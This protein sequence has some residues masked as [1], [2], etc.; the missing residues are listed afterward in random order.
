MVTSRCRAEHGRVDHGGEDE[1]ERDAGRHLPALHQS[2]AAAADVRDAVQMP[3]FQMRP[4]RVSSAGRSEPIRSGRACL[5]REGTGLDRDARLRDPGGDALDAVAL[6]AA[7]PADRARFG[8]L[9]ASLRPSGSGRRLALSFRLI[10]TLVATLG[11]SVGFDPDILRP[12]AAALLAA[13]DLVLIAPR[14][15]AALAVAASPFGNWS[16]RRFGGISTRGWSGQFGV[17]PLLGTVWSACAGPTLGAASIAA[18]STASF[19]SVAATM[20]DARHRGG[21]APSRARSPVAHRTP[22]LAGPA[23]GAATL[24]KSLMGAALVASGLFVLTGLD[25]WAE[26]ALVDASP[27]WLTELTTRF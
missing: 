16:E 3:N 23:R 4:Q 6:R 9:G 7:H 27:I 20:A 15:Q 2:P 11:A 1:P 25:K 13:I 5:T 17:G 10:G 18:A 19:G 21:A 14:L 12:I 8:I 24:A 26:A 22:A